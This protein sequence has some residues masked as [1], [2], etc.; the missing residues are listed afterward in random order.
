MASPRR[1]VSMGALGWLGGSREQ[2]RR[3]PW[4]TVEVTGGTP[5]ISS[6][7]TLKRGQLLHPGDLAKLHGAGE[8]LRCRR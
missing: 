1:L 4:R 2:A 8:G 3:R 6:Y 7:G 5:A